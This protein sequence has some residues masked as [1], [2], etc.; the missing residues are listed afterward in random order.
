[1][2]VILA[3]ALVVLLATMGC[4][5]VT[6]AESEYIQAN[7]QVIEDLPKLPSSQELDRKSFV[8]YRRECI[9]PCRPTGWV[10]RVRYRVPAGTTAQQ[11][12]AFYGDQVLAGWTKHRIEPP[13]AT[14]VRSDSPRGSVA[15]DQNGASSRGD[16]AHRSTVFVMCKGAA[17]ATFELDGIERYHEFSVAVNHRGGSRSCP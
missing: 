8:Y 15:G 6:T 17:H 11:V 7:G 9:V 10:T 14:A 3:G 4:G 2:V 13:T 1:M 12:D 5:S 16:A